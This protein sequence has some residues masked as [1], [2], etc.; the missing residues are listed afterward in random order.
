MSSNFFFAMNITDNI[1][2]NSS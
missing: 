2:R 1:S